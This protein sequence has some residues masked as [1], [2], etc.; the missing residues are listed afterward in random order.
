MFYNKLVNYKISLF[1]NYNLF[2]E[3]LYFIKKLISWITFSHRYK[4]I[5]NKNNRLF[6][7]QDFPTRLYVPNEYVNWMFDYD[8][9]FNINS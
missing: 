4:Y 7:N 3:E 5:H 9:Y 2:I 8:N 6:I 1:E